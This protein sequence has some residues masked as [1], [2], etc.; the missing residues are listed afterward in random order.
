[1]NGYVNERHN[2]LALVG[3]KGLGQQRNQGKARQGHLLS[4][5]DTHRADAVNRTKWRN[6]Q[7]GQRICTPNHDQDRSVTVLHAHFRQLSCHPA[8]LYSLGPNI[9]NQRECIRSGPT[10][11]GHRCSLRQ[12]RVVAWG[13][14]PLVTRALCRPKL[15]SL[16]GTIL[17][18]QCRAFIL[19]TP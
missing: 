11:L 9:K 14:S 12:H 3:A 10:A 4:M 19:P 17:S 6:K 16:D 5:T 8:R 15:D 1:M 13:E 2:I 18:D 7:R